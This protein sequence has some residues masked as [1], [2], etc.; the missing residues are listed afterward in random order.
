MK[1]EK[2]TGLTNF[3]QELINS[4]GKVESRVSLLEHQVEQHNE[5]IL[6]LRKQL[7]TVKEKSPID[8]KERTKIVGIVML[9]E[10]KKPF[11]V[12]EYFIK[13]NNYMSHKVLSSF[14]LEKE[15]ND[16]ILKLSKHT[17]A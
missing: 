7:K 15:A 1:K 11:K 14:K 4:V 2:K 6:T 9:S 16:Y 8:T 10:E 13:K 3:E 5:N 12:I 17:G